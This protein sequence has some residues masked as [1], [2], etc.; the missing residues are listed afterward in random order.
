VGDTSTIAVFCAISTA[1]TA[2]LCVYARAFG[3]AAELLDRPDGVLKLHAAETPLIGGLA[4]LLPSFAVSVLYFVL[5]AP[6]SFMMVALTAATIMLIVGVFDDRI[7]LS[8]AFRL[9]ALTLVVFA[10]FAVEPLLMLRTLRFGVPGANFGVSLGLLAAP[11]TALMIIGFVN[12]TNMADGMNGQLLGSV[13]IWSVFISRYLGLDL[14]MPF[15][16][17]ICSAAVTLGFNLRGRLFSGSSGAYAASV[18]VAF[19]TIAAYRQA[20]GTLPAEEPMFW[21]WLPVLDCVRLMATRILAGKSPF[22]G[23]RNHIHHILQE[24][25]RWPYALV[26]YLA[27]LAA[28]GLAAMISD[29][30]GTFVLVLCVGCYA[31]LIVMRSGRETDKTADAVSAGVTAVGARSLGSLARLTRHT[32]TADISDS[33]A[34]ASVAA[35][36]TEKRAANLKLAG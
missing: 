28:P 32:V 36:G 31:A 4:L 12:A 16:A 21:F 24:Y 10:V 11:I 17:I 33:R 35:E 19:G 6:A 18:F 1:L 7:G 15:I 8:P 20:E 34:L 14:G 22:F 29:P 23:D 13:L 25:A 5:F 9:I 27:L 26:M 2:A 3:H 30:L